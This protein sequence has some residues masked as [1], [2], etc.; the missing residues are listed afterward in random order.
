ML[1][2][3]FRVTKYQEGQSGQ[4][5]SSRTQ[6]VHRIR[7]QTIKAA[8]EGEDASIKDRKANEKICRVLEA[9]SV[10]AWNRSWSS[11]VIDR[12]RRRSMLQGF[13][14]LSEEQIA[15]AGQYK[16]IG[17]TSFD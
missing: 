14:R 15:A 11:E 17:L 1:C 8:F 12:S 9:E 7:Y 10:K 5:K 4:T 13:Y 3:S 2:G 16:A 6:A